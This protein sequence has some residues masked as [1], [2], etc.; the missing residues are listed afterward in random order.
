MSTEV[1]NKETQNRINWRRPHYDV[2]EDKEQFSVRIVMPG[3]SKKNVEVSLEGDN[4]TVQ[5][6]CSRLESENIRTLRRE[7][8]NADYRLALR[9]NVPVKGDKIGAE[10]ADGILTLTLPKADEVKPRRIE[11]Q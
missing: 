7:I 8:A 2:A 10:V 1:A 3:V 11:I 6:T 5:G 4:L 9:L